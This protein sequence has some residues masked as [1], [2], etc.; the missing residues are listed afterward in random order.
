VRL[1][2]GREAADR[3]LHGVDVGRQVQTPLPQQAEDRRH[4]GNAEPHLGQLLRVGEDLGGRA[5][6]GNG[7]VVHD[8][9]AAA[10]GGHLLHGVA[11]HDDA[12][13][14]GLLIGPDVLQNG[15]PA[16]GVQS[17]GGL[18]QDQHIGLHG[19]D[20]GN[21]DPAFLTAGE[22]EGGL[23]QQLAV[24]AHKA[25][26]AAHPGV[27]LVPGDALIFW[28]EGD[29]LPAGL[30]EELVFRVLKHQAHLAP[31]GVGE[32]LVLPDVLAPEQ[33]LAGAGL[34]QTVE[35]LDQGGLAGAGVAD[36]AHQL[37]EAEGEVDMFNGN[38]FKWRSR[39]VHVRQVFRF[40]NGDGRVH[41]GILL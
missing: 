17:G 23:L 37:P 31:D 2:P 38:V 40:K 8:D 13:I 6:H 10:E 3:I 15:V 14:L 34:E 39:A 16:C 7:A 35:V 4:L 33:D 11:D 30:L 36:Q 29:V 19:D 18:V 21:G 9:E 24:N 41:G 22:V 1:L 5:V 28:P 20:P 25:R 32:L 27:Q 26:G 12:G